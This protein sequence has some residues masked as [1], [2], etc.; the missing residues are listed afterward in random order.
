MKKITVCI[1]RYYHCCSTWDCCVSNAKSIQIN[2]SF[3][4]AE[5]VKEQTGRDLVISGDIGWRFFPNTRIEYWRNRTK[6][7]TSASHNRI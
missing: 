7:P 5:Q 1:A 4:I 3:V 6:K 2:L